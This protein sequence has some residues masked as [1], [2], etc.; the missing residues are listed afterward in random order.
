M[1]AQS[2][3]QLIARWDAWVQELEQQPLDQS[4]CLGALQI[5]DEVESWLQISG[6][7]QAMDEVDAIDHRFA[8]ITMED[9]RFATRFTLQAGDGWWWH[10]LPSDPAA[11]DYLVKDWLA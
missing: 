10:R 6:D 7:Q 5:R 1:P 3:Q 11:Q 8:T 9:G 4:E 2:G